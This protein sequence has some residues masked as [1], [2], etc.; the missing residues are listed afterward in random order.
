MMNDYLFHYI[1][2]DYKKEVFN[3]ML[4]PFDGEDGKVVKYADIISSLLE[5]KVEVNY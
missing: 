3:F 5:S 2:E 4:H 1:P